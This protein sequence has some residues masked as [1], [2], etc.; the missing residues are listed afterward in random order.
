M[1]NNQKELHFITL[2]AL[3]PLE[4]EAEKK[5]QPVPFPS[6]NIM[7]NFKIIYIGNSKSNASF[8]VYG[9]YSRYKS[10]VTLYDRA[11]YQLQNPVFQHSLSR[12][13]FCQINFSCISDF[14]EI[15]AL[16]FFYTLL[17]TIVDTGDIPVQYLWHII[18]KTVY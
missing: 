1:R 7:T 17:S 14:S 4:V 12:T 10:S 15:N 11:I 16:M 8:Y 6:I 2:S 5:G 3:N 18:S 13:H 9:N